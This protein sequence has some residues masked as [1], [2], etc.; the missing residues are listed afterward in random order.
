ETSQP[1]GDPRALPGR[2]IRAGR[3]TSGS[4]APAPQ[5]PS[6]PSMNQPT[7]TTPGEALPSFADDEPVIPRS[8]RSADGPVPCFGDTGRWDCTSIARAP[9]QPPSAHVLNF[10][11]LTGEWNLVA[12]LLTIMLLN[13]PPPVLR[14][15]GVFRSTRPAAIKTIRTHLDAIRLLQ[16]WATDTGRAPRLSSWDQADFAAYLG[17]LESSRRP[18]T[19]RSSPA[20][21]RILTTMPPPAPY[22]TAAA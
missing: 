12:R 2:R 13:P 14:A 1:R 20:R 8:L 9:N 18:S 19:V 16:A 17:F 6:E 4:P 15:R 21:L 7:V 22:T 11:V 10:E 3:G 5:R